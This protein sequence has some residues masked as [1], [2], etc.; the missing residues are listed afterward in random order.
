MKKLAISL[1]ALGALVGILAGCGS[2]PEPTEP[3]PSQTP[4]IV[5]VTSSPEAAQTEA[6]APTKAPPT[7]TPKAQAPKATPTSAVPEATSTAAE[8]GATEEATEEPAPTTEPAETQ[9]P[10]PSPKPTRPAGS[11]EFKYPPPV[12]LEPPSNRPVSWRS[13]VL[14]IWSP[15]GELAAD[16]YYHVH[17]ERRPRATGEE[18]YGDYVYTKDTQL[19]AD[20]TFLAPFHPPTGSREGVIYWWVRVVRKT[21]EDDSGKPIGV[22]IGAPSEERTLILEAKPE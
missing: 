9:A 13:T 7:V 15:V 6:A 1:V 21:G 5:V 4:W 14:L 8:A 10:A 12:L 16:E 19:V 18:W 22:D 2:T 20:T 3:P 11:G 17:L